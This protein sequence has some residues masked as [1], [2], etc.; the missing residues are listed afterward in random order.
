MQHITF[1][2]FTRWLTTWTAVPGADHFHERSSA[3]RE[4][5][6]THQCTGHLSHFGG[7]VFGPETRWHAD[8]PRESIKYNKITLNILEKLEVKG[9]LLAIQEIQKTHLIIYN[10]HIFLVCV[11]NIFL[12]KFEFFEWWFFFFFFHSTDCY[13]PLFSPSHTSLQQPPDKPP[14]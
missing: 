5:I 2:A 1:A 4:H 8:R 10:T 7:S 11:C 3:A 14:E 9:K 6:V 12:A 13:S